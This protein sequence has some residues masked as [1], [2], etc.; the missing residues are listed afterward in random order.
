ML[1]VS[2]HLMFLLIWNSDL[3][4]FCIP[5]FNTSHVSINLRLH[6]PGR[7]PQPSFN[8]S[9]V[10]INHRFP[11]Q[12]LLSCMVSIHLMFLLIQMAHGGGFMAQCFNTS[13]VS[14]N[15]FSNA[16]I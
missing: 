6:R 3:H 9:H 11:L 7:L 13:H 16:A 2:I 4:E 10:S 14:I 5:C 12:S 8:T 1:L 15:L